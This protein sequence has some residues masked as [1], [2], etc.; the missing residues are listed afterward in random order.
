MRERHLSLRI[1]QNQLAKHT[2]LAFIVIGWM[3]TLILFELTDMYPAI[4]RITLFALIPLG[5]SYVFFVPGYLLQLIIFPL[6]KD[7]SSSERM[8]LSLALSFVFI[9]ILGLVFYLI[10]IRI[11]YPSIIIGISVSLLFFILI[12][13]IL[14]LMLP[15]NIGYVPT[16]KFRQ[17]VQLNN[18]S[19]LDR[20]LFFI[21]V[22]AV[23][24]AI[25]IVFY[26][27]LSSQTNVITEFYLLG[28]ELKAQDYPR[29]GQVGVPASLIV[30]VANHEGE[31]VTYRVEVYQRGTLI[32]QLESFILQD[33][34]SRELPLT[35]TPAQAGQD[36]QI[37]IYLFRDQRKEP[38][39]SLRLLLM[40]KQK[41]D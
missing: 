16:Y 19:N 18:L 40:I 32:G 23:I 37:D 15:Q 1:K 25:L 17:S 9:A 3:L 14:R 8:G 7:T 20:M 10:P 33:G 38:Y 39:R 21:S 22:F 5:I 13:V 30:G 41:L 6:N 27:V 29:A 26:P 35:F 12:I 11:S 28:K 34:E 24:L 4:S 36:E 2:D 31:T